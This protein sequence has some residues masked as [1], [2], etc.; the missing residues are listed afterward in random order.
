M[1]S[2]LQH[3]HLVREFR[4][5]GE[6]VH[7]IAGSFHHGPEPC[8]TFNMQ[9]GG[10]Q[11][12]SWRFSQVQNM[13]PKCCGPWCGCQY[14]A[15]LFHVPIGCVST[16]VCIRTPGRR[17]CKDSVLELAQLSAAQDPS[18]STTGEGKD[19][20][21]DSPRHPSAASQKQYVTAEARGEGA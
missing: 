10:C 7:P 15:L 14:S 11:A 9:R 3:I 2:S 5:G 1:R 20:A 13:A 16:L 12:C 18:L 6:E 4:Y 19:T 8:S 17:V 21:H